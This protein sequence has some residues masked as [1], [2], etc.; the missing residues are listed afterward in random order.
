MFG[1]I[2]INK[3]EI[4]FKEFDIYHAYYCGFC[5]ILKKEYGLSGQATLT[6]DLTFLIM[7]LSGLYEPEEK[8]GQTHCIVHP[9]QAINKDQQV[10]HICC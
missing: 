9:S 7:L 6:Y 8:I 3:P 1:Y 10:L 4:K 2:T 5:R